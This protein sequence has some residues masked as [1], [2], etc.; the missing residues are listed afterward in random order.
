MKEPMKFDKK[1][2]VLIT[3]S[4]VA[5]AGLLLFLINHNNLGN[6]KHTAEV[7]EPGYKQT[8]DELRDYKQ[9]IQVTITAD[10]PQPQTLRIPVNT[11]IAWYNQD[12]KAHQLAISPGT[13]IPDKFYNF[14]TIEPNNGYPFVAH[15]PGTFHYYD[16]ATPTHTGVVIVSDK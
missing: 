15:Q 10:G 12:G 8:E 16:V 3:V 14:R 13:K 7:P 5:V 9:E 2:A 6:T 11:R 1:L 4:V